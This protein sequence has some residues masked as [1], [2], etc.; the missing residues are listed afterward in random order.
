MYVRVAL[1]QVIYMKS[2][3]SSSFIKQLLI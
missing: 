2:F 3:L 1:N